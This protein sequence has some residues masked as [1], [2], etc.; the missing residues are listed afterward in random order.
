VGAS[1]GA[2]GNGLHG[3]RSVGAGGPLPAQPPQLIHSYFW[4]QSRPPGPT[5]GLGVSVPGWRV[6]KRFSAWAGGTTAEAEPQ[7]L[8]TAAR[9][10]G[11]SRAAALAANQL[12][13]N[14]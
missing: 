9:N 12:L 11:F 7:T 13:F 8:T 3:F 1:S 4:L 14:R 5:G 10:P 6:E 2:V